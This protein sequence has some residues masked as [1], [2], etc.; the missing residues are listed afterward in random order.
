[1]IVSLKSLYYNLILIYLY[2][3][4]YIYIY[5][6]R[7]NWEHRH[8][9]TTASVAQVAKASYTQAVGREFE[10]HLDH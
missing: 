1:M 5:I 10:P 7:C 2:I 6:Y 3:Y 8:I 4:I 9:Y